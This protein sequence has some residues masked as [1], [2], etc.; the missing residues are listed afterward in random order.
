MNLRNGKGKMEK[1]TQTSDVLD[2][3]KS[4]K[5]G[6]TSKQAFE[7]FGATRLSSIIFQLR[8]QGYNITSINTLVPNR[9]GGKSQVSC[10]KLED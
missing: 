9:Y 2:Y 8:K 6:I 3:L 7:M 1:R 10:Y 4:H 5:K